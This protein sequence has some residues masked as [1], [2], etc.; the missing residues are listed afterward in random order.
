M[1]ICAVATYIY[2]ALLT[3]H[4]LTKRDIYYRDVELFK[5]QKVVDDVYG[6]HPRHQRIS[7]NSEAVDD[8]A[9]TFGVERS[10]LLVRASS[11]GIFCGSV[12]SIRLVNGTV[13][14]GNDDQ[15]GVRFHAHCLA[16]LLGNSYSRRGGR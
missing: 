12:L 15:V 8:L 16:Y 4:P 11:K 13:I 7:D 3:D 6:L 10:A 9:A 5:R 2:E 14:Q 1:V